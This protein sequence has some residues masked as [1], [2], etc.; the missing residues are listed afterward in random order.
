MS[1]LLIACG[2]RTRVERH[3][4]PA[5]RQGGWEGPL[6]IV[7]PRDPFPDWESV[8][9]LLL[10]GGRDI[11]PRHWDVKESLHRHSDPDE[12]RDEREIPLVRQAWS[13]RIP[14]LGICR[15]HQVLNVALGGSLV[16]HVPEYYD[17]PPE[18]H[19][20][21]LA[22]AEPEL[23]HRVILAPN[24]RLAEHLE[25]RDFLVN[26]RH[27]QAVKHVAPG[28]KAVGW[29]LD[30]VH[31]VTGPLVEAL[32]A[33][34]PSRWVFGVQWHPEHLVGLDHAAGAVARTLFRV[35]AEACREQ[36]CRQGVGCC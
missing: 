20:F 17:C 29:H 6:C 2:D 7:E 26:S 36:A 34:D 21:G 12:A 3:Y 24:S 35:F 31:A 18:R 30:S 23:R 32:E 4:L 16:Q 13:R 10:V 14:I 1:S 28:L 9:G 5:V 11:H 25:T 15:G 8:A 27:H 22:E 19:Q 33:K